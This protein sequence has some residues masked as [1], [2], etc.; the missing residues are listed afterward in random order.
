[1]SNSDNAAAGNANPPTG[2]LYHK[3]S[4]TFFFLP[5]SSSF[6]SS[7]PPFPL[8]LT[9]IYFAHRAPTRYAENEV[10]CPTCRRRRHSTLTSTSKNTTGN[11]DDLCECHKKEGKR[12]AKPLQQDE[13]RAPGTPAVVGVAAP[14]ARKSGRKR[15]QSC[16]LL[17][18]RRAPPAP[19]TRAAFH[20]SF[21]FFSFFFSFS[22]SRFP[23]LPTRLTH[24]MLLCVSLSASVSYY[25]HAQLHGG[26]R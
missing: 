23:T 7:L 16:N 22:F 26:Y 4:C 15:K 13:G 1:M 10:F 18:P 9:D 17:H 5:S 3:T 8:L 24:I 6:S 21:F 11:Q 12:R 14:A 2:S 20:R 25:S 19:R